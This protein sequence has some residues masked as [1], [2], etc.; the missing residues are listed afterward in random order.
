MVGLVDKPATLIAI[1]PAVTEIM[2]NH[3]AA[4]GNRIAESFSARSIL[5]GITLLLAGLLVAGTAQA[6]DEAEVPS[7]KALLTE[8]EKKI[9]TGQKI[10]LNFEDVDIRDFFPILEE[11]S[12]KNFVIGDDVR[13]RV[14]LKLDDVPLGNRNGKISP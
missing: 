1:L 2:K 7:E 3:T 5:L 6:K 9:Y 10:S 11:I 8:T 13:G 12:G 4:E 14:T